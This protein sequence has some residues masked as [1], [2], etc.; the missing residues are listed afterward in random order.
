MSIWSTL[1][2]HCAASGFDYTQYVSMH[3]GIG[4]ILSESGYQIVGQLFDNEYAEYHK[5]I[6][7][8]PTD[9]RIAML[10]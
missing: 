3:K 6:N 9:G 7:Y 1:E 4:S 8:T 2:M 5:T 10:V